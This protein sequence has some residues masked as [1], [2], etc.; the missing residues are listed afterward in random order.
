MEY[1]TLIKRETGEITEK[2]S[3]FICTLQPVKNQEEATA[4][5]EEMRSKYWD[6]THNVYAYILL[7]SNIKRYS[8]DGEPS[9]TSGIPSLNVLEGE[10]LFNVC[11]VITR[12]F[13]GTLLGT[14]GLVRAYSAAVKAAVEN[15]LVVN[16]CL[17]DIIK[18]Q[19]S[20]SLWGKVK[21]LLENKNVPVKDV[22]YANDISAFVY[23]KKEKTDKLIAEITE[24][25]DALA[26]MTIEGEEF[27]Y[28][29]KDGNVVKIY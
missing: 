23:E 3:R 9:G 25:T 10:G 22:V 20:Y 13:G 15:S 17:C 16:K 14:G 28:T 8:D 12:Y 6:A 29:D 18:I 2:K 4:F 21:N 27:A 1:K 24:K 19:C 7:D 5:I 11:A 26:E